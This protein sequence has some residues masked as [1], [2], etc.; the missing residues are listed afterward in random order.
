M[1]YAIF[2][3]KVGGFFESAV[4]V[5]G[6]VYAKALKKSPNIQ[7]KKSAKCEQYTWF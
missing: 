7:M 5:G 3:L 4:G 2:F 6:G 1:F